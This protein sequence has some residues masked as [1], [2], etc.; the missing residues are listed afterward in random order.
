MYI[1]S[2]YASINDVTKTQYAPLRHQ[3][4]NL[5][6]KYKINIALSM[7]IQKKL[8]DEFKY[9]F[10]ISIPFSFRERT[11]YE[12]KLIQSIRYSLQKNN[13]LLGRTA[14][15]RNMFY[16]GDRHEFRMKGEHYMDG[17]FVYKIL[18]AKND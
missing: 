4:T 7:E 11:L 2:S 15:N 8:Y 10:S 13:L 12:K 18:I 5:F 3:L 14:D 1:S 17:S 6:S 16:I 9:L